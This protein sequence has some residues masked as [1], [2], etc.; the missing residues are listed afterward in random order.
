MFTIFYVLFGLL[1]IFSIINDFALMIVHTAE[2]RALEKLKNSDPMGE[3]K[4][5][6]IAKIVSSVLLI[7]LCVFGGAIFFSINEEWSF[8]DGFYHSFI[9]TMVNT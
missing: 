5:P 2:A 1:V 7:L 8:L 9:T 3:T 4:E 6:H